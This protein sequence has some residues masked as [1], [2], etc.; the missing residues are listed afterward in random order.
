M[1]TEA[2]ILR[3][4]PKCTAPKAHVE[5]L[6]DAARE[7]D[8]NTPARIAAWLAQLAHESQQF[9]RMEENLSYSAERLL[10]VFPK[11]FRTWAEA[12]SYARQPERIANL[13]YANRFGN[14]PPESGDG[15]NY[16]GRG[17]IGLTFADNYREIGRSIGVDLLAHPH[18]AKER[19]VAARIAGHYWRG[20]GCNQ[21]AD[22]G[23]FEGLT[24]RIN[25]GLNGWAD[26]VRLWKRAQEALA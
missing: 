18:K 25:G 6:A 11:Y 14:G 7:F 13:V 15:W 21:L 20:R 26:R 1:I 2:V 8:I 3:I 17:Y 22:V 12:E 5:P 9:N 19:P 24:R 16:R 4:A 10:Q 23:D